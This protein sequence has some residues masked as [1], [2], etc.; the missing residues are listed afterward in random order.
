MSPA[1]RDEAEAL[2]SVASVVT[3]LAGVLGAGAGQEHGVTERAAWGGS[4]LLL[5]V[6]T[7]YTS[8]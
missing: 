6:Q 3:V 8:A 2:S 4:Q 5:R 1:L 7:P